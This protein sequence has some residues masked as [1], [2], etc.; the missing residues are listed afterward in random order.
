MTEPTTKEIQE[1]VDRLIENAPYAASSPFSYPVVKDVLNGCV[2]LLKRLERTGD[3]A[4]T[5]IAELNIKLEE[6]E[7]EISE[8]QRILTGKTKR[9]AKARQTIREISELQRYEVEMNDESSDYGCMEAND[10]GSLIDYRELQA[11]L[12]PPPPRS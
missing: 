3:V 10:D 8:Y 6:A 9:I 7:E 2:A 5:K 11:I 1:L 4:F 12:N